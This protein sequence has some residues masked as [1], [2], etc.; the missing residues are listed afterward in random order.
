MLLLSPAVGAVWLALEPLDYDVLD[1]QAIA[2]GNRK[3]CPSCAEVVRE[4]AIRSRY[5][6]GPVGA[7]LPPMPKRPPCAITVARGEGA[8]LEEMQRMKP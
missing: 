1:R 3:H 7:R 4:E 2:D 6:A 8:A 5:S